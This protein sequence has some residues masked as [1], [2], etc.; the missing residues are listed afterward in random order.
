MDAR[1]SRGILRIVSIIS[2][3]TYGPACPVAGQTTAMRDWDKAPAIVRVVHAPTIFALGD[4]HGDY[5]R[6]VNILMAG[7]LILERPDKPDQVRW[8]GG[9][10]VLVCTGDLIDKGD[11]SLKVVA[12]FRALRADATKGDGRVI[13][14]MGNHEAEFLADPDNDKKSVRFIAELKDKGIAPRQVADGTDPLDVGRFLRSLPFAAR[15]DDWFFAHAGKTDGQ[16]LDTLDRALRD[17][18]DRDGYGAKILARPD[19]ILTAR[20]HDPGPWWEQPGDTPEQSRNRLR[21]NVEALGAKHLVIGHQSG[22]VN[23]SDHTSR[24]KGT[25]FQKFDGLIFLIDVGMSRTPDLDLSKGRLLRIEPGASPRVSVI[26]H[27]GKRELF[28][29]GSAPGRE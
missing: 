18:V 12:L 5:G 10:A 21:G 29:P 14:T 1:S 4:V 2:L 9:N 17:G 26:H 11:H 8:T 3:L 19:S 23:F 20:L 13:V 15:V 24:K 28:W 25:V 22:H 16:N 7:G 27:D 6:L